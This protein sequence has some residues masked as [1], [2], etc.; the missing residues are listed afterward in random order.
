[1]GK[2]GERRA[3]RG[4]IKRIRRK[5]KKQ[6]GVALITTLMI[7][8]LLVTVVIEFN[9]I[10]VAE[11]DISKNFGDE[12]KILFTVI[13]GVNVVGELLR[14]EKKFIPGVTLTGKWAQSRTYF[15]AASSMMEE[16]RLEGE[17]TD[18]NGKINVNSLGGKEDEFNEAQKALW[19]RL[20][21]QSRFDLSAEQV[22]TIIHSV[23]DWIDGDDKM[24]GIYGAEEAFYETRGYPCKN[25]SLD[26]IEELLL[27]KGITEEIFYGTEGKEGLRPY[28][29]V[30]GDSA[31]NINTAPIPVLMALS[32]NMTESIAAD[33]DKYRRDSANQK[34][35]AEKTWYQTLWPLEDPLPEEL[36]VTSSSYFRVDVK[37]TLRESV[38]EVSAVLHLT[39]TRSQILFWQEM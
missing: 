30:Y 24:T 18:E 3:I 20:L 22:D 16:E 7:V 33:L 36:F 4:M 8:A 25:G 6:E 39:D 12:K 9:R 5:M 19:E 37:G 32:V 1:M 31:L 29:T 14:I 10:A 27:I 26:Y 34:Q 11:I 28:F 35:L 38:K 13:A 17:I 15:E 2:G 23:K 21:K